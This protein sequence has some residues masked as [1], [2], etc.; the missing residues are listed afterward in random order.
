MNFVSR[1][2]LP[3]RTL[4]KGAGAT[5]ALPFLDAMAPALSAA[6]TSTPRVGFIYVSHGVIWDDWRPKTVGPDFEL[7][8][9]LKPLE[10]LKGQF[11]ICSGL[12]HLEA[13]T[14]GDGS[15][16]HTRASAAWL[17][18]V[19]VYDRTRPGVEVKVATSADQLIA[20]EL[21]KDTPLP[22]LELTT[23][24]AS[25][26]SCDSGDCFYVNTVSWRNETTPNLTENHPRIVFERLFGD[27][28]SAAE[29]RARVRAT[30]SILDSVS[31][32]AARLAKSLGRS[33]R[34]KLS[35]YMESVREIETRI[36]NAEKQSVESIALPERPISI[37]GTFEEHTKLMFDL[38]V[39]AY[40]ADMTRVF[41]F[42]MARELSLRPYPAISV[43]EAHH[44]VSHHRDDPELMAKKS[45]IDTHHVRMLAYFLEKMAA[46][47]D[48]DGSLLDHSLIL[49][50]SGMG[51]GNLHRHSDIPVLL[52]GKLG[53]KVKTGHHYM[54]KYD[55]PMCNLLL[56][57][58]D[59]TGVKIDSFGDSTGRLHP[60][61]VSLG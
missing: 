36:Q 54:Y 37:P 24:T 27:G 45:L 42:I 32:E 1:K 3:R 60:D 16:D 30:G 50:G 6:A 19:H 13:D 28:G 2:S 17:T 21:G 52:A 7:T 43:P 15:G 46:T 44:S 25:Q 41:T 33:D 56:S 26:G 14:K 31:A 20:R 40:Q 48:G 12:S 29:R 11:N 47:P 58:M 51:N 4:L 9:N 57:I 53:G 61:P 55:T 10:K 35:E 39:L 59:K 5:L 38:L 18:G 8:T 22:S 34:T 49:Y 23:D